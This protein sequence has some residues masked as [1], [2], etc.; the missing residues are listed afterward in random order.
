MYPRRWSSPASDEYKRQPVEG[1]EGALRASR[2]PASF[3][4]TL[5]WMRGDSGVEKAKDG[6]YAVRAR[7]V[8]GTHVGV[9][10]RS[11]YDMQTFRARED[12]AQR[13]R[14]PEGDLG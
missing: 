11:V 13:R 5:S 1:A 7:Q 12:E 14:G 2:G 8:E 4:R 9:C 6:A 10:R 3:S